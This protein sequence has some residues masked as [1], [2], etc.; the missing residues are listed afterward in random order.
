MIVVVLGLLMVR[1][2]FGEVGGVVDVVFFL[3]LIDMECILKYDFWV[4]F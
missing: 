1:G 4:F 2:D 3:L